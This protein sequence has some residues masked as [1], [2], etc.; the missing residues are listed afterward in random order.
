MLRVRAVASLL[1]LFC[2]SV[3]AAADSVDCGASPI[4]EANARLLNVTRNSGSANE[5]AA[6]FGLYAAASADT[7][8]PER[9]GAGEPS[10]ERAFA[11][12]D[13]HKSRKTSPERTNWR[14]T[15]SHNGANGLT[16]DVYHNSGG[17]A[18]FLVMVA[19]RGTDGVLD[20]DTIANLSWLTQWVNPWDQYREAR[21]ALPTIFAD[22]KRAA[23]GR[24]VHVIAT[25]HS[26]GGGLAQH[27][28]HAHPC[29]SAVVFNPS[30]V[31]N[32][33]IFGRYDP[34]IVRI[35]ENDEPFSQ[36]AQVVGREGANSPR[37]SVYRLNTQEWKDSKGST[38]AEHRMT[39][40]AAGM[41]RM[42]LDCKLN[43]PGCRLSGFPRDA[44]T[45]YCYRYRDG[46]N[47]K[48][49]IEVCRP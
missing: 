23:L 18:A 17:Q 35:Y 6:A 25:G 47:L 21:N 2:C 12:A 41:L 11:V 29:V 16:Y 22:A 34:V 43:N 32:E 42:A 9:N 20:A 5:V 37:R 10:W 15:A 30:F 7:Y 13:N 33:L 4:L 1:G 24:P 46:I 27:V 40:L 48:D 39:F 49:D 36:V 14:L 26:L 38:F 44:R 45:L 28:A 8:Q 19:F 31:T 3:A